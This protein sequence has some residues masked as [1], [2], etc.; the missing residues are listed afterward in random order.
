MKEK[1]IV[2]AILLC[3]LV[4]GYYNLQDE[5]YIENA[6]S[7]CGISVLNSKVTIY[8]K[9]E[10]GY[11]NIEKQK[12]LVNKVAAKMMINDLYSVKSGQNGDRYEYTLTKESDLGQTKISFISLNKESDENQLDVAQYLSV[13]II[14]NKN[15]ENSVEY[16]EILK[17]IFNECNLQG[18]PGITFYGNYIGR[19][20]KAEKEGIVDSFCEKLDAKKKQFYAQSDLYIAY[21]YTDAFDNYIM[22]GNDKINV[23]IQMDYNELEDATEFI[24]TLP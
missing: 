9:Y 15:I 7:N 19:L 22:N 12:E 2:T 18:E 6:F 3:L 16:Y 8:A 23:S 13:E 5:N 11:C 1:I 20:T 21:A 24:L 17:D 10:D 4:F 14:L